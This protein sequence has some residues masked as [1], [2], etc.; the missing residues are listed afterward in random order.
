MKKSIL[1]IGTQLNK[2]QL[3]LINGGSELMCGFGEENYC[4]SEHDCEDPR[5]GM[6]FVSYDCIQNCCVIL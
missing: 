4:E 3:Q 2:E 6:F 1:N 5:G